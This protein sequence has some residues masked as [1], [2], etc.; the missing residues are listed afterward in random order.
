MTIDAYL[1]T[2]NHPDRD[3]VDGSVL[4]RNWG[5]NHHAMTQGAL[6]A[7]LNERRKSWGIEALIGLRLRVSSTRVRVADVCA[8]SLPEPD[9]QVPTK[10]PLFC[11]EILSP[12]DGIMAMLDKVD[13]Y[14]KMRVPYV[15]MIHPRLRKAWRCTRDGW[16]SV[17][18][19]RTESPEMLVPLAALFE[20]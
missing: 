9:E 10:P 3:F 16:H 13:D 18:E 1:T 6:A 15:W 17:T 4:D 2:A 8:F 7:F 20:E 5:D 14:L 12:E 19:L 11:I